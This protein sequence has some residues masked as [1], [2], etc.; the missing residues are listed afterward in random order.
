[1]TK[2]P[3]LLTLFLLPFYCSTV[4][5]GGP[6]ILQGASG[7]TPVK[8]QNPGIT[9]HVES[10]NL[11]ALSNTQAN[12]LMQ[13]ALTLWNDAASSN[14]NL[15][16]NTSAITEDINA[17]NFA[18][19]LPDVIG[20][21]Q[22]N[23]D[24]LNPIVYDDD[25]AIIDAFF[26]P[27]QSANTIGFAASFYSIDGSFFSEGYAV[28]NGRDIGLTNT[29][30]KLLIAHEIGHFIGLD[31]SQLNID[32]SEDIFG[33]PA[34]CSTTSLDNYPVMYPFVCRNVESL[35]LDDVSA[36]S[37]LYPAANIG[38]TFGILEGR[39]TN[40]SGSAILGANVFAVNAINGDTVS[41]V[42]DYL[43]Q[44]T[45]FYK[46]YL[47]PGT[48][49]LHVNS[50]NTLFNGG[51]SVGP[52]AF[53]ITDESFGLPH[54]LTEAILYDESTSSDAIIS[55][56]AN[57]TTTADFAIDVVVSTDTSNT[58][59]STSSSKSS[60]SKILGA[61]S[62]ITLLLISGLLK[63]SRRLLTVRQR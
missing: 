53:S 7:N 9:V 4:T 5:A 14:I 47:P 24:N 56:S 49:T 6:L 33:S 50:V 8:Y 59:T 46:L 52:Y 20:S 21:I 27:D 39:L 36:V 31:H 10:G 41:I 44:R 26:G 43:L 30:F 15:S 38:D 2:S 57:Q 45:G 63:L 29:E 17:G 34:I 3:L 60:S 32:T 13:E 54:P 61:S 25:G 16:I 40:L 62:Y 28:I 42:S 58:N 22:N 35:H 1:M 37:A 23:D 18:T 19:V 48:Y 11:G 12:T 55:I 51:S